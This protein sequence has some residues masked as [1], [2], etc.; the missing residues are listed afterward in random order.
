MMT[1]F[2]HLRCGMERRLGLVPGPTYEALKAT[3]WSPLFERLM[4]NRLIMG[5]LRYGVFGAPG[6]PAYDNVG[7]MKR[8]LALYEETGNLEHLVDLANIAMCEFIEGKHPKRHFE[9]ADDGDHTQ[10]K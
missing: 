7:S 4:R 2:E 10:P 1:V 8:R 3:Q 5:G 9:A 6:K